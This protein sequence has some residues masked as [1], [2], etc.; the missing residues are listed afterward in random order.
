MVRLE[1]VCKKFKER[2]AVGNLTM[3]VEKGE[4][5]VL[6][7]PTGA[8]KTT[9]LRITAGLEKADSGKVFL[10]SQDITSAPVGARDVAFLFEGL[11][12]LPIYSVYDNIA[13]AL[14]SPIY[15]ETEQEIRKRVERVARDLHIDRLLNRSPGTLSGGEIQRV[16]IARALIRTPKV[17]LLDEPLS[18][19]DLKL[20]EELRVEL[21]ELHKKYEATILYATH[22]YIGAASVADRIGILHEG[23]LHQVGTQ[24]ELQNNPLSTVVSSLMGNPPMNF[25]SAIKEGKNLISTQ[26]PEFVFELSE[27]Q[28]TLEGSTGSDILLGIWPEDVEISL[29]ARVGFIRGRIYG[30]EYRGTDRIVNIAVGD[31]F[32]KR[33]VGYDFPG[34]HG[35]DC[36]FCY[37]KDRVYLFDARTGK[38]IPLSRSAHNQA[39]Y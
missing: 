7:G 24:E 16:A 36:W 10:D 23:R 32:L 2:V 3:E 5:F 15:R 31:E 35:D 9:T 17:Y 33:V 27:A 30:Q 20:R 26:N 11:N 21:K 39:R 22:D 1:G 34:R 18:N 14:R 28:F 25:F 4:V 19:L 6:L 37:K 29:V 38:R 13:F 12:L 8:G